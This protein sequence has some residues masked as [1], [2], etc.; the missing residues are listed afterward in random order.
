MADLMARFYIFLVIALAI[1]RRSHKS[2][3]TDRGAENPTGPKLP[4]FT[5]ISLLSCGFFSHMDN[6][7]KKQNKYN[8]Y[9][10][11]SSH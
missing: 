5:L 2:L 4:D 7:E 8:I 1:L 10:Q 11:I 3:R 9:A 6:Y